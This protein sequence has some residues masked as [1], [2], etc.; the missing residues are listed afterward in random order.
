LDAKGRYR[1]GGQI[2]PRGAPDGKPEKEHWVLVRGIWI[3]AATI[4]K[5][6][7]RW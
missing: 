1:I 3:S 6:R 4:R 5:V 7:G 2:T